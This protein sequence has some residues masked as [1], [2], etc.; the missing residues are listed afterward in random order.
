MLGFSPRLTAN[1]KTCSEKRENCMKYSKTNPTEYGR[2]VTAS[3]MRIFVQHYP[4]DILWWRNNNTNNRDLIIGID[5]KSRFYVDCG[6]AI[7]L[8]SPLKP[9]FHTFTNSIYVI[10]YCC[11]TQ[12]AMNYFILQAKHA[13]LTIQS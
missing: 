7:S 2:L 6:N 9:T 10:L 5:V 8:T 4:N 3:E 13:V 12:D 11:K 1:M